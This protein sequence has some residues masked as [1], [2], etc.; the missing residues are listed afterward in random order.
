M[1]G[2]RRAGAGGAATVRRLPA[3]VAQPDLTASGENASVPAV[4]M[5]GGGDA[6]VA[7]QRASGTG[8][9]AQASLRDAGTNFSTPLELG[10]AGFEVLGPPQAAIDG[11]GNAIVVWQRVR[12]HGHEH[13]VVQAAIRPA[14]GAFGAPVALSATGSGAVHPQVAMNAAG[15]AVVAWEQHVNQTMVV[16]AVVRPAGGSFS[17]PVRSLRRGPH[18]PA[19][20]RRARRR[21][22]R[23]G[24][25]DADGPG[26]HD[27]PGR[28]PAGRRC[29]LGG[30]RPVAARATR[31]AGRSR[32]TASGETV[33]VWTHVDAGGHTI[34]QASTRPPGGAFSAPADLSA[35]GQN[36]IDP[37]VAIDAAGNALAIWSRFD[38]IRVVQTATRPAGG[39]FGAPADLS[40][41]GGEARDPN[42]VERTRPATLVAA[43]QRSDGA[44]TIVAGRRSPRGRRDSAPITDLSATGRDAVAPQLG[45]DADGD[46]IAV[47][48]AL[49]RRRTRS[50]RRPA[51]TAPDRSCAG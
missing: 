34:V 6:V 8:F 17:A 41:A 11:A 2:D 32:R 36:A 40:L 22:Q 21:R 50:S 47:L 13:G 42:V 18:G 12:R 38:G 20:A 7:W 25:V 5:N 1:D 46:A 44:N 4:A 51:T 26:G 3:W 43:W 33:A 15:D 27:G 28:D 24:R 30:R 14:G 9:F 16:Q 48:A 10:P 45:I 35:A 29:V 37:H 19:A 49:G 31:A 23:H 39:A